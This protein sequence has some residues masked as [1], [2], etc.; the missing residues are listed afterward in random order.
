WPTDATTMTDIERKRIRRLYDDAGLELCGIS[1]NV[2]LLAD[3]AVANEARLRSY[4]DF[5]AEIQH[6]GDELIVTTVSGA[7]P[8]EWDA[9]TGELVEIVG[10]LAEDA[11]ERGVMVGM[12]PHVAHALC[13]PDDAV[14]L[15][16]Q[17]GSPGATIHFDISHFNVQGIP[18]EESV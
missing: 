8:G 17:V 9:R 1:G 2:D 16:E 7:T 11:H 3:D 13:M 4:L 12:E 18:M 15:I 6:P 10:R 14:W 5:A